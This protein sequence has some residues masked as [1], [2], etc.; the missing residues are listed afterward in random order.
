MKKWKLVAPKAK[1][2]INEQLFVASVTNEDG[3]MLGFN[4]Y[5]SKADVLQQIIDEHNKLVD[6]FNKIKKAN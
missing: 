1:R 4:L 2:F 6:I 5:C 3:T